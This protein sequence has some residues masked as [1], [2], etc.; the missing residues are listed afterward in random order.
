M[1]NTS[2]RSRVRTGHVV[3]AM[4]AAAL[5][6]GLSGAADADTP[7][8]RSKTSD[9]TADTRGS[10]ANASTSDLHRVATSMRQGGVTLEDA[11]E[12]A[13]DRVKGTAVE[14]RARMEG[15]RPVVDVSIL[16]ESGRL[17]IVCVDAS[18]GK[19][20]AARSAGSESAADEGPRRIVKASSVVGKN[21]TYGNGQQAGEIQDLVVD[22]SN[23][24]VAYLIVELDDVD[25]SMFAVPWSVGKDDPMKKTIE[26]NSVDREKFR[27]APS[28]RS[29]AW[30]TD[31]N[32]PELNDR[33][34]SYY[35]RTSYIQEIPSGRWMAFKATEIL[36]RDI[37]NASGEKLGEIE[38]LAIDPM[39]G[40]ISYAVL[41][42][43]G[44]LG[45]NDKLFAVPLSAIQHNAEG[46][47]RLDIAKE[48]LEGAP[49]FNKNSWPTVADPK[50]A[51]DAREYYKPRSGTHR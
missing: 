20:V 2:T 46:A 12:A 17:H 21:V 36:G 44:F 47:C 14:T 42:F 8:I 7:P 5:A 30:P 38:D 45:F 51:A 4:T 35:G 18:D 49:G 33:L 15:V 40:E 23:S 48:R 29:N 22:V 11:I 50:L 6:F 26:V 39:T 41:S 28:F 24:R 19:V 25:D 27:G 43:G 34:G 31:W 3:L 9:R 10:D 16:D 32:S 37:K 13:T 1:N